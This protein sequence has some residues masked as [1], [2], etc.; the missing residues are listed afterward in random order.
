MPTLI[1][2]RAPLAHNSN[3]NPLDVIKI[4]SVLGSLGHYEGP[5]WGV[6][7]YPDSALFAAIQTFQ[8]SQGLKVDG[9]MKPGGETIWVLNSVIGEISQDA[10][11]LQR[12]GRSGDSILAHISPSEARLLKTMGGAGTVNPATGLLE[13]YDESKK[14]GKYIWRTAGDGKVRSAHADRDGKT[15]SWDNPP[16]GG[17]PGEA[18]N[19]RCTAE[20]VEKPNCLRERLELEKVVAKLLPKVGEFSEAERLIGELE[21]KIE[22]NQDDIEILEDL[23]FTLEL[24]GN[25]KVLPHPLVRIGGMASDVAAVVVGDKIHEIEAKLKARTSELKK[26]K[27]RTVKIGTGSSE[28]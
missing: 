13:F 25:A 6:S 12:M 7:K 22:Q 1:K 24:A 14:K 2:I 17:H 10:Q 23:K 3:A 4:K 11:N 16:E 9:V 19:C 15:Y 20:E 21:L 26:L 18:P 8:K 5:E 27:K 28:P